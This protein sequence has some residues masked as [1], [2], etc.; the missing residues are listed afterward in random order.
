MYS[1]NN[2]GKTSKVTINKRKKSQLFILKDGELGLPQSESK[3][4]VNLNIDLGKKRI[5]I[6]NKKFD[7][8]CNKNPSNK[9][10]SELFESQILGFIDLD[11]D[12][13]IIKKFTSRL[14]KGQTHILSTRNGRK[15]IQAGGRISNV[16]CV[17]RSIINKFALKHLIPVLLTL[18]KKH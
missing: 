5:Y 11:M 6:R 2:F 13:A 7:G 12:I 9:V 17:L 16:Y 4:D 14:G 1:K 8:F 10:S 18:K 3:E 15:R